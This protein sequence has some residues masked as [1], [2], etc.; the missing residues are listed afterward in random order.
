M[1]EKGNEVKSKHGA[2]VEVTIEADAK[3]TEAKSG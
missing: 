3:D 2:P 1:D